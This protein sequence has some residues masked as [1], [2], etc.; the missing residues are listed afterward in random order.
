MTQETQPFIK[1]AIIANMI[2]AQVVESML[3]QHGIPYRMRSFHDT[4]YDGL[5]QLQKGW[6]AI[7]AP[8]ERKQEI[9][10]IIE[11]TRQAADSDM[12]IENND[13]NNYGGDNG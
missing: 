7:Y 1:I 13:Q 12:D 2:E 4:A 10:E 9:L 11:H 5:F 6:G 8:P 3:V